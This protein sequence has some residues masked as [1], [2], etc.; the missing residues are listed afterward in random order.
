M[1]RT[2]LELI[3]QS[4]LGY[5]FDPLTENGVPHPFSDAAKLL[6]YV[7]FPGITARHKSPLPFAD[8]YSKANFIQDAVQS[9]LSPDQI[10]E[11]R[12]T[13]VPTIYYESFALEES[14]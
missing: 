9:D 13:K 5:S 4:R 7:Y 3:G 2:A 14:S 10:L 1:A 12:N 11:N 8:N 6:T